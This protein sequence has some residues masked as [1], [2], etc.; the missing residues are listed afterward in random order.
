MQLTSFL[1][2]LRLTWLLQQLL[3]PSSCN[4]FNAPSLCNSCNFPVS[5]ILQQWR[6]SPATLATYCLSATV[7]T[8]FSPAR[9][10]ID[11]PPARVAPLDW[12][13]LTGVSG[14]QCVCLFVYSPL[15]MI[16]PVSHIFPTTIFPH[17]PESGLQKENVPHRRRQIIVGQQE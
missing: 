13:Y 1:Q 16:L 15:L 12:C 11:L 6:V 14:H 3:S 8:H 4:S 2:Q 9:V 10:T 5:S 17:M 7:A